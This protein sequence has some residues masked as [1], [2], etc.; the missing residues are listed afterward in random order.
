MFCHESGVDP[1]STSLDQPI[2]FLAKVFESG[3]GYS[4]IGTAR[5][6]LNSKISTAR[7]SVLIME[8]GISFAKHPLV[9][10]FMKGIFSLRLALPGQYAVWYP[11]IALDYVSNLLYGLRLKYLL[12]KSSYFIVF[13]IWTKGPNCEVIKY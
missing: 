1:I 10:G 2:E 12:Q 3:V 5:L 8:N 6:A 9:Q 4:S 11:A 7:L 13:I